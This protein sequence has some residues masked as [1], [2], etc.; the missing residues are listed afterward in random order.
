MNNPILPGLAP[1]ID[2]LT[3]TPAIAREWLTRNS[4]NRPIRKNKV[5][6][7]ARDMTAGQWRVNGETVKF[8][9]DGT[10]LDGQHRL[11][12]VSVANV[13]VEMIVVTGLTSDTQ[14]TMDAGAKRTVGD[15]LGLDG[16]KNAQLLAAIVR[17][18]WAWERGD[19][20][21]SL[22][23]SPTAT[24]CA[25]FIARHPEI[26]RS[27]E[28]ATRV[29][30]QYKYVFPAALGVAHFLFNRVSQGDTALFCARL[31][32][33]AELPLGHPILTLRKRLLSDFE[34]HKKA[35]DHAQLA[36]FIRAWNAMRAGR[37]PTHFK[38]IA[39]DEAMPMPK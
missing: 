14:A 21:L 29:R 1:R 34:G 13:P 16:E 8:A 4:H 20:K 23:T 38:P 17:R 12:A 26:R 18:A 32:D 37:T 36:L 19:F 39:Q 24:E 28:I 33:G 9:A 10:L 5:D 2:V 15:V 7:Y 27:T 11:S 22:N 30:N 35:P 25:D 6:E 31:G 3:V